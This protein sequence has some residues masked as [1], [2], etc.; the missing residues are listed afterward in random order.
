[1][2][3]SAR[4][5]MVVA[6][7]AVSLGLGTAV[8][9]AAA[10]PVPVVPP[11][12]GAI[13][14]GIDARLLG[15]PL[16]PGPGADASA[17]LAAAQTQLTTLQADQ[18]RLDAQKHEL[19]AR[20]LT[21]TAVEQKSEATL[22]RTQALVDRV[23]AAAYKGATDGLL[24]VLPSENVLDLSRR[25]KLAGQAGTSLRAVAREAA[26]ARR[27]ASRAGERAAKDSVD[28]QQQ[29]AAL[30]AQIPVAQS[31]VDARL[32]QAANDLPARK[33]AGLGIPVAA[34]D[35]YLRAERTVAVMLP[36]CGIQ[37]WVLAGI[38]DG[39]SGHGTHGGARADVHGD[40]F[41][42]IVGIPLDGTHATQP[43]AD[44]D[45]GLLDGD[46]I[47]DHAVGAMQFTP[48]TWGRWASDGNGDGKTDPQNLYDAALGAARKLCTDAGPAGMHT[49]P[50]IASALKPYT[51]TNALVKAKLA[52]A[53]DYEAQGLPVPPP[54]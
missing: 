5:V 48:G 7:L 10:D 15:V 51:V 33:V 23:A 14:P 13:M 31:T 3:G 26:D 38:A 24:A 53:K 2:L 16:I 27:T 32:S 41:P 45:H 1:M 6:A 42:P 50:Q 35:A 44:T 47:W 36:A 4:R 37:W 34:L 54:G 40:V 12:A 20:T 19:D 21:L 43:V 17:D 18:R 49:D 29:R 9:A 46:P 25:M 22:R 39:E 52:R 28:V 11:G 30:A 8:A